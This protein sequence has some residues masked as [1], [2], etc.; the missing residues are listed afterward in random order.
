MPAPQT[1]DAFVNGLTA[2]SPLDGTE[3]MPL[4]GG[5]RATSE[6]VGNRTRRPGEIDL[7]ISPPSARWLLMNNATYL[8]SAYPALAAVIGTGVPDPTF[9][10]VSITR[11]G[12]ANHAAVAY[13]AGVYVI[14]GAGGIFST[15]DPAIAGTNRVAS[16]T[17]TFNHII[18]DGAR[19]IAV[20]A[21]GAYYTSSDGI[22]WTSQTTGIGSS[23]IGHI[24]YSGA[25]Y[26]VVVA[27]NALWS[28][29]DGIT[30]T[31]RFTG[32]ASGILTTAFGAG[33]WVSA[34]L[35]GT[36][37][38]VIL[39]ADGLS[40]AFSTAL[41]NPQ[42]VQTGSVVFGN[43][44]FI[45]AGSLNWSWRSS[46]G[47]SF[48][49]LG[50]SPGATSS[51]AVFDGTDWLYNYSSSGINVSR[52]NFSN[53][54]VATQVGRQ[55]FNSTLTAV[56]ASTQPLFRNGLLLVPGSNGYLIV[57]QKYSYDTSLYF[58]LPA[59]NN[60]VGYDRSWVAKSYIYAGETG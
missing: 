6:Q 15:T 52:D 1:F 41:S 55:T 44:V 58:K 22:T 32:A 2:A 20:G 34:G 35:N 18:W 14:V 19:F 54:W 5:K 21:A 46:D 8:R 17:A 36:S 53:Q 30:Y 37:Y 45:V 27:G 60:A 57:Y 26:V 40:W 29:T 51:Y 11:S 7:F 49:D 23:A 38:Q 12:T 48:I 13:G 25:L 10:S 3:T 28:S 47:L 56:Q 16:G 24:A 4:T 50:I 39:S 42:A 33:R 43:G 31:S 59:T 9:A